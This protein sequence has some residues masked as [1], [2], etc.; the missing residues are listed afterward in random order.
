MNDDNNFNRAISISVA[1]MLIGTTVTLGLAFAG[2]HPFVL[3]VALL[4]LF[5][6]VF[7]L[8]STFWER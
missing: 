7:V 5:A 8:V 6:V 4:V 2:S 1:I 3:W